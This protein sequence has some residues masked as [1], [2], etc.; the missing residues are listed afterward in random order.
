MKAARRFKGLLT[1]TRP[2]IM[3]SI[4]G[5]SSR[6][7]QPPQ[8]MNSPSSRKPSRDMLPRVVPPSLHHRPHSDGTQD[9][10][11]IEQALAREGVHR[12]IDPDIMD[13]PVPMTPTT[14]FPAPFAFAHKPSGPKPSADPPHSYTR[15]DPLP[16]S[17]RADSGKALP[18]DHH[19]RGHAHNPLDDFLY[20]SIGPG[21]RD[22]PSSDPSSDP[23]AADAND[24]F[25][26]VS[27]SPPAS[28]LNIYETAYHQ[29]VERIR[30]NS[31]SATLYLTRRVREPEKYEDDAHIIQG[32]PV[33]QPPGHHHQQ[34]VLERLVDKARSKG[35]ATAW[36]RGSD[37]AADQEERTEDGMGKDGE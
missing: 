32:E 27:E 5:Q 14:N 28:E 29:E 33:E 26:T 1:K 16:K 22:D 31:R 11:P 13:S 23:S 12:A 19:G 30:T 7:V 18:E 6:M 37:K 15:R 2:Y 34:S 8:A 24:E 36:G 35:K 17:T 21:A 3:D 4:L 10:R 20:L 25:P 9:R